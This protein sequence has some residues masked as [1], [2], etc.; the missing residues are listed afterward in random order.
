MYAVCVRTG[1]ALNS[2]LAAEKE[3]EDVRFSKR[4]SLPPRA[5]LLP[6][7][8]PPP[9]PPPFVHVRYVPVPPLCS[10]NASPC[11]WRPGLPPARPPRRKRK[12]KA[13]SPSPPYPFPS[14]PPPLSKV[15]NPSPPLPLFPLRL[16]STWARAQRWPQENAMLIYSMYWTKNCEWE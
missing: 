6:P 4:H 12:K 2:S 9:P 14:F 1:G 13:P 5:L 15:A 16:L 8:P 3:E 10:S 7:P 11:L